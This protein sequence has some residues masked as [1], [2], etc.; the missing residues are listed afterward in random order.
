MKSISEAFVGDTF[1][2]YKKPVEPFPG[3]KQ[4]KPMVFA[5]LFPSDTN[6]FEKVQEA[7][8]QLTL[9]DS[10]VTVNKENSN[11]LGQGWRLG[12]LGTLHMDV[13]K[14]RLE[15]E[16]GVQVLLSNPTVPYKGCYALPFSTFSELIRSIIVSKVSYRGNLLNHIY[17]DETRVMVKSRL[18]SGEIVTDFYD[19]L[20]S[21]SSGFA[22]LDYEEAGYESAD[23]IKMEVLINGEPVDALAA[24]MHKGKVEYLGRDIAKRLKE[25][26]KRQLFDISIQTTCNGRVIARETKNTITIKTVFSNIR[27]L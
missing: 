27:A 26:I 12:F 3:F 7:I 16:H 23:L 11:A 24:V 6:E 18:P 15:E 14:Q 25:L 5:G 9:N 10:S 19:R 20:K 13:F 17:I 1:H 21:V 4:P 2:L 8:E 22:T